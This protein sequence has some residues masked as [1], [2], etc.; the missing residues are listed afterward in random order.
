MERSKRTKAEQEYVKA[1]IQG[2]SLQR[3]TDA[4]IADH[5]HNE[6]GIEI[7]RTTVNAT[8]NRIERSAEKW[9]IELRQS[10]Y[11]Y[12][13]TYKQRI[14]SLL[15]YQKKL[16]DIISNTKKDEVKIRAISELHSIEM[17][18]FNLWKQLPELDIVDQERE[19]NSN[20]NPNHNVP[21][22]DYGEPI[23]GYDTEP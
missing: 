3:M 17:D 6:K 7:A 18:L 14:D 1:L 2:L 16:H 13:A 4:E 21:P 12:I 9:Y 8:K 22:V 11:K 23:V 20:S 5:L 19:S 15:S 10:R